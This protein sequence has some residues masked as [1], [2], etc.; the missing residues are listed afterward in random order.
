MND[1]GPLVRVHTAVGCFEDARVEHGFADP[2][3]TTALIIWGMECET[4]GLSFSLNFPRPW[5][6]GV[7][8]HTPLFIALVQMPRVATSCCRP[9]A[10]SYFDAIS[11]FW[12]ELKFPRETR[13]ELR[14]HNST[15]HQAQHRCS[16]TLLALRSAASSF[17]RLR[18]APLRFLRNWVM[19]GL[20]GAA[21]D[22]LPRCR[23]CQC[24]PIINWEYCRLFGMRRIE[25]QF[26]L[27]MGTSKT[28]MP[29]ANV[30]LLVNAR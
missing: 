2:T 5:Y 6:V 3:T 23:D 7:S 22:L 1:I 8:F 13:P 21:G 27:P 16:V 25:P 29:G 9:P 14:A 28:Q 15:Q 20:R 19:G 12:H 10:V 18:G 4:Y 30:R 26:S 24:R 11:K 17:G